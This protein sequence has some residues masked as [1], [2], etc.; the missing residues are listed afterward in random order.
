M[1]QMGFTENAC[2][3]ALKRE[4][5]LNNANAAM[6]WLFTQMDNPKINDPL[7]PDPPKAKGP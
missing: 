6:E 5:S 7:P 2:K 4:E 1:Q 3:R